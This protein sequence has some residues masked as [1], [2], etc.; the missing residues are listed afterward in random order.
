MELQPGY[1]LGVWSSEGW[2]PKEAPFLDGPVGA[3]C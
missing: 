1:W 2:A 3:G